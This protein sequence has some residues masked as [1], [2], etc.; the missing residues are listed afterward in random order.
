VH[1]IS[2]AQAIRFGKPAAEVLKGLGEA[3]TRAK[4]LV[5]HNQK[6]DE[7]VITAEFLR[8][9]LEPPFMGMRRVCTMQE[10]T[11]FCGLP[12]PYG[13]K[14]PTLEELHCILFGEEPTQSHDAKA[15]V[16][17]CARCFFEL[18]RRRVLQI[19]RNS[20]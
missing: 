19:A 1:G 5:A 9:D 18:K 8:L 7:A 17:A 6:F 12:G 15:D 4:I 20:A 16:E 13:Y 14:W 2:T 3:A 10:A 11:E